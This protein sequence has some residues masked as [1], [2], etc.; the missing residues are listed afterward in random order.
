M[1]RPQRYIDRQE[2]DLSLLTAGEETGWWDENGAPAPWPEDFWLADG[3][4]N[5]DWTNGT[6]TTT[7]EVTDTED[8]PF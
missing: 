7:K 3:T 8:H 6:E 2:H 1:S 4:P 5:P